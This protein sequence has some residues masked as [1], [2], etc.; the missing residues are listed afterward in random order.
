LPNFYIF[1]LEASLQRHDAGLGI[2]RYSFV[3]GER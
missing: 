3:S 1:R 2:K